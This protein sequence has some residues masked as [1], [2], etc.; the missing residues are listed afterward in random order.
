MSSMEFVGVIN[1]KFCLQSQ[2]TAEETGNE[3]FENRQLGNVTTRV[4]Y[5]RSCLV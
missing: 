2:Y 1:V 5:Q 3:N 4:S